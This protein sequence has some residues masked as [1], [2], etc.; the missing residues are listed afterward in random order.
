MIT[1]CMFIYVSINR[2]MSKLLKDRL[3]IFDEW[4]DDKNIGID[5]DTITTGSRRKIWWKCDEGHEW[6][7]NLDG[8]VNSERG[9]G[10]C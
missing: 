4:N 6:R 8:R 9:C 1:L 5:K 10:M 7:Q 3:D 2:Y